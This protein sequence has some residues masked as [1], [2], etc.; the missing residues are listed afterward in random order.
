[1]KGLAVSDALRNRDFF[2]LLAIGGSLLCGGLVWLASCGRDSPEAYIAQLKSMQE[3]ERRKAANQ[4]I[5]FE[6][7]EVVP[8]LIQEADSEYIR[9]RFEVVKL[10]GRFKDPRGVP[11]LIE[12]LDDQSPRVAAAAAWSLS[13]LRAV[14]ALPRLLQYA[15]DPSEE[16]HQYV[17]GALGFCHSYEKEPALSD[18]AYRELRRALR[19]AKPKW[20]IAALQGMREFGY[21]DVAEEV[22]RLSRDPSPQVRHVAVQAL[23]QIGAARP[24]RLDAGEADQE[25]AAEDSVAMGQT[26]PITPV[27]ERVRHNI[28]EALIASLDEDEY[29]SIRTKAIRALAEMEARE[30]VP[31]LEKIGQRGTEED[32]TEVSRALYRLLLQEQRKS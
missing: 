21:R 1:L 24:A 31:L 10:L 25:L 11:V 9:V 12:A 23:G 7:D 17:L 26:D 13:E 19:A 2:K 8:L 4:L 6:T 18:S 32:S 16:V 15:H 5:R 28:I 30:V 27:S 20:R 29:Q 14:E 3:N 22:I